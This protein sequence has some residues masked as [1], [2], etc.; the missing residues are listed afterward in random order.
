VKTRDD[1][2]RIAPA[3]FVTIELAAV[4]TGYSG[5]AIRRKIE[6]GV[7]LDGHEYVRAPDGR[8]LVSLEGYARWAKGLRSIAAREDQ[9]H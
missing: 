6:E 9:R 2:V 5:K 7:W 8:I 3:P 1:L 4:A